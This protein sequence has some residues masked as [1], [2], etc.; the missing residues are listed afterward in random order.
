M[1]ISD[2]RPHEH[3]TGARH[4]PLD[5]LAGVLPEVLTRDLLATG[6]RVLTL[7]RVDG[8]GRYLQI[9]ADADGEWCMAE[10]SSDHF[11]VDLDRW[12][13]EDELVLA[14]LGFGPPSLEAD[15]PHPNWWRLLQPGRPEV[16]RLATLVTA[17]MKRAFGIQ[18]GGMVCLE[19]Q[20][21]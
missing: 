13:H 18:L 1:P 16:L 5:S 6:R 21:L 20:R 3:R 19:Q 4:V 9:L 15:D 17:V 2:E 7:S 10:V 12:S 8:S 14:K 11:L